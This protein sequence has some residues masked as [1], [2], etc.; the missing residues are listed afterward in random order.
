MTKKPIA[1]SVPVIIATIQRCTSGKYVVVEGVDDIVVYRNLITIYHTKG[2]K[3]ISAG[4]RD[5]VLEVFNGLCGSDALNKA[6]FIVDQDSW[7]FSGIPSKYQHERIICTSGYSI[8]NDIYLDKQLESLMLATNVYSTF[9]ENLKIYLRWFTLAITRFCTDNNSSSE[10]LDIHPT[11]FF[12]DQ[13]SIDSYCAL[14]ADEVFPTEVYNDLLL[15]YSLKFRGKC[16]LPLAVNCLGQRPG[17]AKY[18]TKTI[19]EETS[20]VGRGTYLNL[21]FGKVESLA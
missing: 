20:C 1:M 5:K 14:K 16:L 13:T 15:N 11:T 12:K 2:I 8:E 7:I 9:E 18:N 3:V 10:K 17:E 6:I 4:G 19:M 21:L